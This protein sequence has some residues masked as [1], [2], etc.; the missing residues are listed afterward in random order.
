MGI[1]QRKQIVMTPSE[2]RGF[3]ERSRTMTLAT[4]APHSTPHLVAMWYG[5]VDG[6]ICFETKRKSQKI[7]NLTRNPVAS[8]LI[9]DGHVYE[10]LRGVA[11]EGTV[12]LIEDPHFL[13]RVGISVW[14]RYNG[15][16][17]ESDRPAVE[18]MLNKRIAGRVRVNRIRS[19]D[20]RKLGIHSTR[21]TGST[22]EYLFDTV[23]RL[24]DCID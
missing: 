5:I 3:I 22:A 8:V 14:E 12:D 13:W 17:R 1:N 4:M 15:P 24:N 20:H 23:R 16:Y 9:E 2:I 10:D 7:V 19:W 21:P 18:A 6:A 11:V